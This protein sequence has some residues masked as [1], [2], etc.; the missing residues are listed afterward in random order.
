MVVNKPVGRVVRRELLEAGFYFDALDMSPRMSNKSI[1]SNILDIRRRYRNDKEMEH[2]LLKA[3]SYLTKER[4]KYEGEILPCM[5]YIRLL[6]RKKYGNEVEE[7]VIKY[8]LLNLEEIIEKIERKIGTLKDILGVELR[9]NELKDIRDKLLQEILKDICDKLL[10]EKVD[11]LYTFKELK[12]LKPKIDTY[13]RDVLNFLSGILHRRS[14][15]EIEESIRETPFFIVVRKLYDLLQKLINDIE[16]REKKIRE[17][18]EKE[19]SELIRDIGMLI[20]IYDATD[21]NFKIEAL[22]ILSRLGYPF[23]E[24]IPLDNLQL[25]ST[26]IN[27][28]KLLLSEKERIIEKNVELRIAELKEKKRKLEKLLDTGKKFANSINKLNLQT[29]ALEYVKLVNEL[30]F[31]EPKFQS[32]QPILIPPSNWEK[33][34]KDYI[35][36]VKSEIPTLAVDESNVFDSLC[37]IIS[38]LKNLKMN[39]QNEIEQKG[40]SIIEQADEELS[41]ICSKISETISKIDNLL[42]ELSQLKASRFLGGLLG[43]L[44]GKN[45]KVSII[46]GKTLDIVKQFSEDSYQHLKEVF[47]N[48]SE[49]K[50]ISI[51]DA[52]LRKLK[53][54]LEA[55]LDEINRL[56]SLRAKEK[57]VANL[58]D[59]GERLLDASC[60]H[61]KLDGMGRDAVWITLNQK[62]KQKLASGDLNGNICVFDLS[63]T[64]TEPVMTVNHGAVVN[65][66]VII[67]DYNL[68]ASAGQD[69]NIVLFDLNSGERVKSVQASEKEGGLHIILTQNEKSLISGGADGVIRLWKLP[70]LEIEYELRGH[71]REITCLSLTADGK[72]LVSSDIS[73]VIIWDLKERKII[74][75]LKGHIGLITC[76]AISSDNRILAVGEASPASKI[77]LWDLEKCRMIDVL[78]GHQESV[79]WLMFGKDDNMLISRDGI[80]NTDNSKFSDIIIWN[81]STGRP[82]AKI[83]GHRGF[84]N[85]SIDFVVDVDEKYIIGGGSNGILIW[86]FL[87]IKEKAAF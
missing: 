46:K 33:E 53:S 69:G 39:I 70:Q 22:K 9:Q 11:L 74:K 17:E 7:A 30:S 2:L 28:K 12:K 43:F 40:T 60:L 61:K 87:K 29:G 15:T 45:K 37:E 78:D 27:A 49:R 14:Y 50:V 54:K 80:G 42:Q 10:Q 64:G 75:K 47:E 62:V 26:L 1:I 56:K 83:R 36:E 65:S 13:I 68:L 21:F 25:L 72:K 77:I 52:E 82:L 6:L 24:L 58:I 20:A 5:D 16:Q 4:E 8:K 63:T 67:P 19:I 66:L 44:F 34:V 18:V 51:I 35:K 3:Q 86:D 32:I 38:S 48:L 76:L 55:E 59:E 84:K 23:N 73:T 57:K 71:E 31:E 85:W 41:S 79:E 81:L